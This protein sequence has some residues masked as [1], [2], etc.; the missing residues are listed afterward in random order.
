MNRTTTENDESYYELWCAVCGNHIDAVNTML[1]SKY[2]DK[3]TLD[4]VLHWK[5]SGTIISIIQSE[6]MHKLFLA[7]GAN[8]SVDDILGSSCHNHLH[9]S[10][11]LTYLLSL[12]GLSN[13]VRA[14]AFR[15]AVIYGYFEACKL[16]YEDGMSMHVESCLYTPLHLAVIRFNSYTHYGD[17]E[18]YENIIKWMLSCP[19]DNFKLFQRSNIGLMASQL[20]NNDEEIKLLIESKM[21]EFTF[22]TLRSTFSCPRLSKSRKLAKLP[23]EM[24]R[25]VAK[26][27]LG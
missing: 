14:S 15:R 19:N 5:H 16:L 7:Y 4:R 25:L 12:G 3:E 10:D 6:D 1:S 24:Y 18:K 21:L 9:G 23:Q 8:I 26:V 11:F 13:G 2:T 27:L 20:V 17:G 22:L